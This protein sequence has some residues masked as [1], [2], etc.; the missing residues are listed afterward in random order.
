MSKGKK[1]IATPLPPPT[2]LY[3]IV[4]L[5][6]F[7]FSYSLGIRQKVVVFPTEQKFPE[8]AFIF[9]FTAFW[10][11]G[12]FRRMASLPDLQKSVPLPMTR[13]RLKSPGDQSR[14]D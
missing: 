7:L 3:Y 4:A 8:D 9:V 6:T 5:S 13:R 14:C 12:D 10:C 1:N 2:G 11:P